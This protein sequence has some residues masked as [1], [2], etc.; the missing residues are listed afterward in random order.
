MDAGF[1]NGVEGDKCSTAIDYASCEKDHPDTCVNICRSGLF[2]PPYLLIRSICKEV[3]L[4]EQV[5]YKCSCLW[6]CNQASAAA[7]VAAAPPT[8]HTSIDH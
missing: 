5:L 2:F 4:R 6:E 3:K 8:V 1:W 7:A